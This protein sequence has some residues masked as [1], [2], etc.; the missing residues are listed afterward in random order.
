MERSVRRSFIS[1][2][3]DEEKNYANQ[4]PSVKVIIFMSKEEE[5]SH[6]DHDDS[7]H[8]RFRYAISWRHCF[9]ISAGHAFPLSL[10]VILFFSQDRLSPLFVS[11]PSVSQMGGSAH[12]ASFSSQPRFVCFKKKHVFFLHFYVCVYVCV[13][14]RTRTAQYHSFFSPNNSPTH[15]MLLKISLSFYIILL[16]VNVIANRF[17][18]FL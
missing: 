9:T 18:Q 2:C 17:H 15:F 11:L 12:V 5:N 7:I 8:L 4:Q 1:I 6:T 14:L 10:P 13:C 3:S 16:L